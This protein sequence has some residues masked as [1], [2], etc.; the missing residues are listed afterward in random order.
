MSERPAP[1]P[2]PPSGIAARLLD[3]A[4]A[5]RRLPP[6]D[7]RRPEAFHEAKDDLA[8]QLRVIAWQIARTAH[9]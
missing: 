7:H 1:R 5:A 4:D 9:R 2:V 8:A 3:L 6:P